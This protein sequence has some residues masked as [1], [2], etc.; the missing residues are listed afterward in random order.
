MQSLASE[1]ELLL[2]LN[3][4]ILTFFG[5]MG[6]PIV[7]PNSNLREKSLQTLQALDVLGEPRDPDI[8]VMIEALR[9]Y[10]ERTRIVW[11]KPEIEL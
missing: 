3:K 6:T 8:A 4:I 2:Q 1:Y 7:G 11:D 9:L 5:I 10:I